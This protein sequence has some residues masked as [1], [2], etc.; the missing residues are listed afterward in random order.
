M[1]KQP[2]DQSSIPGAHRV[3]EENQL[4]Q[5]GLR[6]PHICHGACTCEHTDIHVKK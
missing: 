6:P 3:E 2:D 4:L 1:V 5:G